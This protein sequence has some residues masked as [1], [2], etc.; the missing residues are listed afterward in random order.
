MAARDFLDL[1]PVAAETGGA[2]T[3]PKALADDRDELPVV[4]CRLKGELE[5]PVGS[6]VAHLA[7]KLDAANRAQ[8]GAARADDE[9]PDAGW[10]G[11]AIG[12]LWREALV[13]VVVGGDHYIGPVVIEGLKQ[14]LCAG[15][16]A[17]AAAG[18]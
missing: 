9:H 16:V 2:A 13:M 1:R 11:L 18:T 17:V 12:V 6:D 7:I 15:I 4:A 14:R 3:V 10:V 5:H 8:R